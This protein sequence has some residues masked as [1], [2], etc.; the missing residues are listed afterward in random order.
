MA[1]IAD[2]IAD[3]PVLRDLSPAQ[4][5]MIAGCGAER[6]VPAGGYLMREGDTASAFYVVRTG[7]VAVETY[8]PLGGPQ[9]IET[10]HEGDLVG[11]SWLFEPHRVAF[12]VRAI[13]DCDV[14]AFDA[15]C[16]R[17]RLE[18]DHAAAYDIIR[19]FASVVAQRLQATRVR[20]LDLYGPPVGR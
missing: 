19:V 15:G 2:L 10:L 12:D 4:R 9:T 5:E 7:V 6:T 1:A 13:L 20:L 16:L 3:V 17:D 14:L 8:D 18:A 11:W